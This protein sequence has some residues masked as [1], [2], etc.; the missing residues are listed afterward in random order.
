M[1][2][3][4]SDDDLDMAIFEMNVWNVIND[5]DDRIIEL[6][7]T[8]SISDEEKLELERSRIRLKDLLKRI[9]NKKGLI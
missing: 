3:D 5:L 4:L 8:E 7:S 6:E 1:I 2:K 9:N